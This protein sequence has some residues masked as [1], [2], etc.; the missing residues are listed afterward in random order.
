MATIFEVAKYYIAKSYDCHIHISHLKL[1]K[2][3]YYAQAWRIALSN[4]H[5]KFF[6]DKFEAWVHGP[7][8]PSLFQKY[9][10]FSWDLIPNEA[11]DLNVFT[12]DER[13]VLEEVWKVYGSLE[14]KF[15][16]NLTHSEKPWIDARRGLSENEYSNNQID[17]IHMR[18]YYRSL[19][20]K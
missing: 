12:K 3:C 7:V 14:A 1:Q 9:R 2:L 10:V 5:D 17:E 15:L 4:G 20:N 6:N 18:D 13:K 8:N 16:E 11:V 19:L